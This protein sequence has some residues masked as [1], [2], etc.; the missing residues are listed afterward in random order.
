M[1]TE[2]D[3]TRTGRDTRNGMIS[4]I[5]IVV[6]LAIAG[7]LFITFYDRT[8]TATNSTAVTTP[9]RTAPKTTAPPTN[10]TTTPPTTAP[11]PPSTR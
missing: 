6:L 4:V 11:T 10:T 9:Q 2:F 7:L 3:R 8:P 5:G 1:A